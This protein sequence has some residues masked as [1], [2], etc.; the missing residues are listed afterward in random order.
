MK[1]KIKR[2]NLNCSKTAPCLDNSTIKKSI[3]TAVFQ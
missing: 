3:K 2:K 1:K